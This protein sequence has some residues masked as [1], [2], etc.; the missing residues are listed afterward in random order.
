MKMQER[1][2]AEPVERLVNEVGDE[3]RQGRQ[4]DGER[5]RRRAT[6]GDPP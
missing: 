6:A 4:R 2:A 1:D 5:P 3:R